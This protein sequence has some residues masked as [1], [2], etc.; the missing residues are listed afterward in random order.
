MRYEPAEFSSLVLADCNTWL[1]QCLKEQGL[2][3]PMLGSIDISWEKGFYQVHWHFATWTANRKRLRQRLKEI[4]PGDERYGRPVCVKR[5]YDRHFLL[6]THK[7]IKSADLLRRNRR[8]L[9]H[10]LVMLDRTDPMDLMLF[11]GLYARCRNGK[12]VVEQAA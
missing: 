1:E 11:N 10:L 6:Y 7:C 8:G 4:F 9:S 12:L 2:S 5:T 3:R